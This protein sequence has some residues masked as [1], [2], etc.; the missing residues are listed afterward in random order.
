MA[1]PKVPVLFMKPAT[2]LADPYPAPTPAPRFHQA[3]DCCDYESELCVVIGKPCKDVSE[4]DALDYVLGY[5]ASNDISHRDT[6]FEQSQWG[7]SKGF[8]ASCPIGPALVSARA[9]PDPAK[10]HIK[11]FKNGKKLQDCGISDLIFPVAKCVS[12]LSRATTLEPGTII[13]TGTPAGVGFGYEPKEYLRDGDEFAV[14]VQPRI[15]TLYNV[16]KDVKKY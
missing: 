1:V 10:L 7:F 5:T 9:I 4:A 12:F 2:A 3:D 6:Q 15:G 16:I 13:L 11:G 8:D 14:E